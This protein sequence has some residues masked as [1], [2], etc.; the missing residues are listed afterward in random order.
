MKRAKPFSMSIWLKSITNVWA[1]PPSPGVFSPSSLAGSAR[2]AG[3]LDAE[4]SAARA[5][6]S[7]FFS[8]SGRGANNVRRLM[9]PSASRST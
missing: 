2:V 3:D 8:M 4:A 6:A 1:G 9:A 5:S 7:A